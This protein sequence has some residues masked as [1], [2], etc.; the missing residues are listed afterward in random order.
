MDN[1]I[2]EGSLVVSTKGRDEGRRYLVLNIL[3]DIAC[4]VDGKYKLLEKPKKKRIKH[5]KNCYVSYEN[6]I[7]KHRNGKLY[8]FEVKTILKNE[9]KMHKV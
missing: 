7:E 6:L 4:C 1:N 8:D 9:V 3:N 2:K 5:L